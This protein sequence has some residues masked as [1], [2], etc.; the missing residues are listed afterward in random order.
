[1]SA[2]LVSASLSPLFSNKSDV[3]F[4]VLCTGSGMKLVNLETMQI[5]LQGPG[6]SSSGM[7]LDCPSCLGHLILMTSSVVT[8]LLQLERRLE[9]CAF[10]SAVYA[11]RETLT[12]LARGPP[13]A[14]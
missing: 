3:K 5:S 12:A 6:E 14:S 7:S 13:L 2:T 8:A 11:S 1:M 10:V 9:Q 4:A